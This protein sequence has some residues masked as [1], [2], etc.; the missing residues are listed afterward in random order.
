M[1]HHDVNLTDRRARTDLLWGAIALACLAVKILADHG[2]PLTED[3][4][5]RVIWVGLP[6]AVGFRMLRVRSVLKGGR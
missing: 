5:D 4:V 1:T 6:L 3:L 2:R